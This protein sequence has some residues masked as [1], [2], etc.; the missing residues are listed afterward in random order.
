MSLSVR[1]K[2]GGPRD[3]KQFFVSRDYN[4]NPMYVSE[5]QTDQF[6]HALE[7][8]IMKIINSND[9]FNTNIHSRAVFPFVQEPA[10]DEK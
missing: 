8:V 10:E 9:E 6:E 7:H 5:L 3:H 4:G 1:G 2:R